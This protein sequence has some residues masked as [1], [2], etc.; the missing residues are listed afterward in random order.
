MSVLM[1]AAHWRHGG[2]F[3]FSHAAFN[4]VRWRFVTLIDPGVTVGDA[5]AGGW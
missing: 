2:F 3:P 4:L 5:A 1:L